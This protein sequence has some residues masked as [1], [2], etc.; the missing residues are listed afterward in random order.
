VAIL[1]MLFRLLAPKDFYIHLAFQYLIMGVPDKSYSRNALCAVSAHFVDIGEI[2][3]HH[4]LNF[5]F[6]MLEKVP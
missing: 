5:L 1:F 6:I 3:V 4:C 2:D